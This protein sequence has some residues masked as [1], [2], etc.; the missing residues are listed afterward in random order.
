M[1][2]LLAEIGDL[3]L[4]GEEQIRINLTFEST[5]NSEF[6]RISRF[7]QTSGHVFLLSHKCWTNV[8]CCS[9]FI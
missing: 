7:G 6:G 1:Q 2:G 5:H 9:G 3:L 8:R 4:L